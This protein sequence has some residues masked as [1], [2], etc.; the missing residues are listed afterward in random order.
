VSEGLGP[1][2]WNFSMETMQ[3]LDVRLVDRRNI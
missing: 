3:N 2:C 1:V